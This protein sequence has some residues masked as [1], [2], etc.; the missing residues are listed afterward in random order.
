MQIGEQEAFGNGTS[1]VEAESISDLQSWND[2]FLQRRFAMERNMAMKKALDENN[3]SGLSMAN[4]NIPDA[5]K[6]MW[7]DLVQGKPELEDSLSSN[8]KQMKVEPQLPRWE[9]DVLI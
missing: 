6:V 5:Q 7:S 9:A 3:F 1:E 8:A 2:W 4:P